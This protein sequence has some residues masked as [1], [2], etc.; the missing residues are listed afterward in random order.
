MELNS[1]DDGFGG[2]CAKNLIEFNNETDE[3]KR[4]HILR[5]VNVEMYH[6]ACAR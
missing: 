5:K 1:D 3:M 6:E 2:F 4:A